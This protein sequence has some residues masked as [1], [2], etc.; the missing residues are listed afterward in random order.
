MP[1]VT[2][3]TGPMRSGTSCVTGLL[4]KCGFDL[5]RNVP[6]RRQN[7]PG[8]PTGELEP[9]L[10]LAINYRLLAEADNEKPNTFPDT[11]ALATLAAKRKRYFQLFVRKF[12]GNLLKDPMMCFTLQFWEQNWPELRRVIF[13]LR[14]PLEVAQSVEKFYS[15]S[16]EQGLDLWYAFAHRFFNSSRRCRGFVFDFNAFLNTPLDSYHA[17]LN[18]LG[19]SM[20][21]TEVHRHIDK[22]L[23]RDHVH[24]SFNDTDL[25]HLP[26][27][28]RELY[29]K[30]RSMAGK[31]V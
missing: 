25:Q 3:V 9:G 30:I 23:G 12:D 16:V 24:W 18:W 20:A 31:Q 28:V 29:L 19:V 17:L 11:Q 1:D 15:V 27:Q 10:L 7:T 6:V 8:N 13:C 2:L 22:F 14:H 26:E 4:E 21:E 5:G